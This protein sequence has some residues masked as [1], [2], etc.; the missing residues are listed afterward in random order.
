MRTALVV[1]VLPLALALAGCVCSAPCSA[2]Y[3]D[4]VQIPPEPP[5]EPLPEDA[6][7]ALYDGRLGTPTT[8][9]DFFA[10]ALGTELVAFGEL[11]GHPVGAEYELALLEMLGRS[12]KPVALAMEFFERDTQ[13]ALD[14]YLAGEMDEEAFVKATRRNRDYATTHR[15]L[16]EWAKANGAAIIAANAPRRLVSG[17]RKTDLGYEDY[18]ASLDEADRAWLPRSTSVIEDAYHARFTSMMPAQMAGPFFRSQSL[19]DDAMAESIADYLDANPGH[20]VLLV[21]GAFHVTE[22]LGTITKF[23]QRR[24]DAKVSSLVMRMGKDGDLGWSWDD[25]HAGSVVLKV[26]PPKRKRPAGPN[27]HRRMPK[28]M[29]PTERPPGHP[30]PPSGS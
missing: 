23:R 11:H 17:Y 13:P 28:R 6:T 5:P 15:P 26:H 19:W 30:A 2:R 10:E 16:V 14:A 7:H 22:N 18:V 12:V 29:P 4:T 25:H 1:L 20:R 3:V 27:P 8:L 9:D 21:V 24:P